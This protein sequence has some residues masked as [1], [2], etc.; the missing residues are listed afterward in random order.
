[1]KRITLAALALFSFLV[2]GPLMPAQEKPQKEESNS[3]GVRQ[4]G[5]QARVQIV[6]TEYDGEKK[7]KSLPYTLVARVGLDGKDGPWSKIRMGSRVPVVT[8]GGTGGLPF[9]YQYIDVGTNIDCTASAV[10]DGR[11]RLSLT[12]ERSWPESENASEA[13]SSPS[14]PDSRAGG[15]HQPIIRQF[16]SDSSVTLKEGQTVETNVATDPVSGKVIKLEVSLNLVK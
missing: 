11:Y 13:K 9:Q 16:R 14:D 5:P 4:D 6:F 3:A 12:M 10:P 15:F 2:S 1:M 8:G 7:I